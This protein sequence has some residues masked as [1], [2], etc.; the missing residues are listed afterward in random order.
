MDENTQPNPESR[1][2]GEKQTNEVIEEL[3]ALG[4]NLRSL[5]QT[6]WESEERRKLQGEI[7]TG[8]NDLQANLSQALKDFSNSPTGQTLKSD[9][10]DFG[11]RIRSGEVETKVRTE[12]L[13]ALRAANE[14]L[15][16]ASEPKPAED[17]I[18]QS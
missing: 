12:V 5:L 2:A 11:E 10:E 6:A 15:K 18:T 1:P 17:E 3:R 8:L 9:L 13:S 4:L 14:G 16:K 7:E